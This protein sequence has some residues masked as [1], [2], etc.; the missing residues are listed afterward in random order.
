MG[1]FQ[2]GNQKG[3]NIRDHTLVVHAVVNEAQRKKENVDIQFTDIKQCFDS[4]WL[5][6]ATND[7]F[8]S[9]ITD[10][11]LNLLYEGN[12]LTRM[13]VETNFGRS[14]RVNLHKVVMQGSV[15]GGMICS[16]QISKICNKTFNEGNVYM[17]NGKIP[18]PAL[19]MVD[20]IASVT[21]CKSVEALETNVKT[22][23]FIQRKKLEGQ[24][25]AGK[26]QWIHSGP[27][28][29]TN[30]FSING[31]TITRAESY[32]YLGDHVSDKWDCLFQKRCEKAQGYSAM[33]QAMS[34]EISLGIRI[35]EIAILLHQSVFV[36][37]G[38]VNVETWPN[39][40][41][42][43]IVKLEKTEQTF[44]RNIL[45][46]HSKTPIE[47]LYLELGIIPLRFQLMKRRILYLQ[48]ILNRDDDELTKRVVL[49]Q[50]KTQFDGDF[51]KQAEE[52]MNEL[53][54]TSDH[55]MESNERLATRVDKT[56]KE[57][58]YEYLISLAA[59]HSKVNKD[60]YQNCD[61]SIYFRTTEFTPELANLL[62]KFRTR[63]YLVK[64]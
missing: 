28:T 8:D 10:R 44:M 2:V 15:P 57:R 38:L 48:G 4:V 37:G 60:I 17:Y 31:Q 51:Y 29:C 25:G 32:K 26:C 33:C 53:N 1:Q 63:T 13:C 24:T 9:G 5:D 59:K 50:K 64:K 18:I 3:R 46:A 47:T 14:D 61:G 42:A 11:N 52:S 40:T 6:E 35:Y 27:A 20:D 34:T 22:D 43:R 39:C 56:M 58:A 16:N 12:R 62:F 19:A 54:I 55:L 49:E 41:E 30:K 23:S 45:R 21:L 7:L 36:N